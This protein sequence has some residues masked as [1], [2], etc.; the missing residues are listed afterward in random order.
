[1]AA[2]GEG[3]ELP[4]LRELVA[5]VA[6]AFRYM[7]MPV[8]RYALLVLAPSVL[9]GLVLGGAAVALDL[10]AFLAAPLGVLGL[11]PLLGALVYPKVVAD[12]RRR[13]IREQFHLFLTHI[14]VLS[15]TNI[16]RVEVFRTL[17]QVEEYGALAEEMGRITALVDTWNQSLD[18]ACRRRSKR[19]PSELLGD[20]LERLAYTVGAGQS[21]SDFLVDEQ[22]SNI[23]EFVIRY[24]SDLSKLD[25]LQELYLSLMLSTTFILV[26]AT[27]LP[28]L[29]GVPPTLLVGGVIV[30]F[31]LV[32]VGFLFVIHTVAP[33]DPVWLDPETDH[34]PMHRVW[35]PLVVGVA[36]SVVATVAVAAVGLGFTPLAPDTLPRP[37]YLAIPTT[38]L[39]LPGL[40]MRREER[41]VTDRDAGFL[42][43]PGA[44]RRRVGET[45]LDGERPRDAAHEGLR[46][47]HPEREQ[48]LQ[49][50]A[51][52]HRRRGGVDAVRRRDGLVSHPEVRRHVR[53]RPAD[54]RRPRRLGQVISTNINEVLRVREQRQQASTTFIGVVYGITAASMFSAFI[55]LEIAGQML[56]I[57]SEIASQNG[58]SSIRCS[59]RATT[60]SR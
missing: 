11:V 9:F 35:L 20:F 17:A 6:T 23:Q 12:R 36:L 8:E 24:E 58:S 46:R 30:M 3:A 44:R 52:P 37:I 56:T 13:E 45:D 31:A 53:R 7:E 2:E 43:H 59:R 5:S 41:K 42:V 47:A 27:V 49:A 26:F 10:P 1:M 57:T 32:Q 39:L 34:S 28:L 54:G 33:R 40:A 50:A 14:T 48:P 15:L 22:E 21:L 38:P 16:E 51:H 18:D 55:G 4:D 19:V 60:T 29:L 25:V